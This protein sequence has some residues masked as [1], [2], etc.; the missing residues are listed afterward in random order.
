MSTFKIV[1]S[2]TSKFKK[3]ILTCVGSGQTR[4]NVSKGNIHY[5]AFLMHNRKSREGKITAVRS[6]ADMCREGNDLL[7]RHRSRYS[8]HFPHSF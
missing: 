7:G 4:Q 5:Q 8:I 2:L 6:Q 3:I 1:G